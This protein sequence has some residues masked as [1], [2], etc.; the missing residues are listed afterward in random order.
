MTIEPDRRRRRVLAALF[1]TALA[2]CQTPPKPDAR[3]EKV[4][5]LQRLGFVA[6]DGNWELNLGVKLLFDIDVDELSPEGLT[7][8][9][10]VARS[11][12][13]VGIEH[14][15]VEGHTDNV[16]TAKHNQMLSL[17]RAESVARQLTRGGLRDGAIQRRGHG[18]A[19]PV[20]E[21]ATPEGRSQN[22][23]VVIIVRVD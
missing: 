10:D 11:L 23:R 13:A 6:A 8:V 3:A 18:F 15:M 12:S 17:R 16:G 14:V 20:A 5:T 1:A 9:A 21:N 19:K 22:R 4:A 7:A 2:G